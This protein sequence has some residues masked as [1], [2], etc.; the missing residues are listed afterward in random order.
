MQ[1]VRIADEVVFCFL[2]HFSFYRLFVFYVPILYSIVIHKFGN[3]VID[4]NSIERA[5][6]R[7]VK[8]IRILDELQ[9]IQKWSTV[10]NCFLVGATAYDLI[11]SLDIDI[12][13]FSEEINPDKIMKELVSL[14]NNKNVLELKYKNYIE[15]D[16]KGFYFKIIYLDNEEEWNIDMWLFSNDRQGALSR[17]LVP[18][19]KKALSET[20]RKA[21]LEIKEALLEDN[22]NYSSIFIYQA[23][24]DYG[25]S[26]V[27]DFL[28]WS[29]NHDTNHLIQWK[30]Q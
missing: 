25:V 6:K 14:I 18:L 29:K 3:D 16:F 21:I 22:L 9:L 8:A 10:G 19:M 23:V 17:D 24:L 11:V 4:V 7:K 26:N 15:S 1:V 2:Q 20:T 5:N 27:T 28:A 13:T 12:E 30:P